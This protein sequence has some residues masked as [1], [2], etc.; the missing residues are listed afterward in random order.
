[1]SAVEPRIAI[2]IVGATSRDAASIDELEHDGQPVTLICL[3]RSRHQHDTRADV[4]HVAP[5]S[6]AALASF[7]TRFLRE[8][9]RMVRLL[10]RPVAVHIAKLL[11]A[12]GIAKVRG[13]DPLASDVQSLLGTASA[14]LDEIVIDWSRL[15][16]TRAG[17]RWF[18]RRINSIA[19]EISLDGDARRVVVKQQRTHAGG[20]AGERFAHELRVLRLLHE[21]LGDRVPRVL[22]ADE[23]RALMV[24]ERARGTAVDA[25][26][27]ASSEEI[28][29]AVRGAGAWIAAMQ[30]ATRRDIEGRAVLDEVMATAVADAKKLGGADDI[31]RTLERLQ[32]TVSTRALSVVGHHDD[33]WPGNVFFDAGHVTV[34]DFESYRDGLPLEDPAFF[35]LRC[36][37]LRRRFGLPVDDLEKRFFEGY[38]AEPDRDAL[39][40]FTITKGLR[41]LARGAGEG[42][43]LPQ[44]IWTRRLVRD[45][46]RRALD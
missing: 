28:A 34:I 4:I 35:L 17:V 32:Q 40:L 1:M 18:T 14:R 38:G 41:M 10:R 25:L 13:G 44:R 20:S 27:A 42:L 8:P 9:L 43:P 45:V 11:A 12:R 21:A 22:L 29:D 33:Y 36:E 46:I 16:A 3:D 2:G 37:M 7:V 6:L 31:L 19:A 30:H 15:G 26:F 24:M 23:E 5:L 39:R